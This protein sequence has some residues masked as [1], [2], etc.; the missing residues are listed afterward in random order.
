MASGCVS[1]ILGVLSMQCFALDLA[2]NL[3][4][5]QPACKVDLK[6]KKMRFSGVKNQVFIA[7]IMII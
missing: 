2:S 7:F 1:I 3:N 4:S 6:K 5:L